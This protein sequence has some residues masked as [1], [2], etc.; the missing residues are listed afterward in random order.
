MKM[1]LKLQAGQKKRIRFSVVEKQSG[2][3]ALFVSML[4]TESLIWSQFTFF[5]LS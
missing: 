2:R 3:E 5:L 4:W 1:L